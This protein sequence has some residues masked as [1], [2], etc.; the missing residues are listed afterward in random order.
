MTFYTSREDKSQWFLEEFLGKLESVNTVLDVGC[1]RGQLAEHF[2]PRISYT[3]IDISNE[4]DIQFNLDSKEKLPVADASYDAVICL[5][6]LEHI[7]QT[8]FIFDEL[9]RAS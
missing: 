3:G 6:T 5:E 9:C 2:P 4:A 7:E 8:H 1:D